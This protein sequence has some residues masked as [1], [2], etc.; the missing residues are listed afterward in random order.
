[1]DRERN[2]R[3][4]VVNFGRFG[5]PGAMAKVAVLALGLALVLSPALSVAGQGPSKRAYDLPMKVAI[6]RSSEAGCTTLCPAWIMAEGEITADTP[7]LFKKVLAATGQRHLPVIIRSPG[8]DLDAA[9]MIGRMIRQRQLAV[10][11]GWTRF[12]GCAPADAACRLPRRQNGIYRGI[13]VDAR[14]FCNSACPLVLAAGSQRY[15]HLYTFVG[16]HQVR[17]R[18]TKEVVTYREHYRIIDG[19]KTIIDRELVS[20]KPVRTFEKSGIDERLAAVLTGYFTEMGV[21]AAIIDEMNKAPPTAIYRLRPS[22]MEALGLTTSRQ[23]VSVITAAGN[24]A[25]EQVPDYCVPADA[26]N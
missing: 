16:V 2:G 8:G 13:V 3:I 7:A 14:G 20:R 5:F 17:T 4:G 25:G 22:V 12:D 15:A 23:P 1:V 11:V 6:V 10:G 19:K 9:M 18:F 24:C 26:I 21:K